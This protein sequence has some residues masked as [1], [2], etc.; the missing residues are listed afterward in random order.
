[1]SNVLKAWILLWIFT[2]CILVSCSNEDHENKS[3]ANATSNTNVCGADWAG[4]R[5][6][7]V[8]PGL[9]TYEECEE[10]CGPIYEQ[11][12]EENGSGY[13]QFGTERIWEYPYYVDQ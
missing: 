3:T 11:L 2:T 8:F 12:V 10:L 5:G 6:D 9:V 4:D 7:L 13:C 1:M